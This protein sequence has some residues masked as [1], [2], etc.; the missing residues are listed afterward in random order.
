MSTG[1]LNAT[2]EASPSSSFP[3]TDAKPPVLVNGS[4]IATN[5]PYRCTFAGCD[6]AYTKPSRLEEHERTHTNLV[7][8]FSL[9][10]HIAKTHVQMNFLAYNHLMIS[11]CRD[12]GLLSVRMFARRV[13]NHTSVRA[14]SRRT[15][16]VTSQSTSDRS[17]APHKAVA[18]DSARHSISGDMRTCTPV[19]NP[20][21]YA[22]LTPPYF[23]SPLNLCIWI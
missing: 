13:A 4:L 10:K 3:N 18:S 20:S 2:K 1:R 17:N 7:R 12:H 22:F 11:T 16:A 9:I 23:F 15:H 14:T 8:H 19:R 21:Q 6:K 5:R